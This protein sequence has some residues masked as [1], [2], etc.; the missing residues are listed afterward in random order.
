VYYKDELQGGSMKKNLD[1]RKKD[2][3]DFIL[4]ELFGHEITRPLTDEEYFHYVFHNAPKI[5]SVAFY[6]DFIM[7]VVFDNNDSLRVDVNRVKRDFLG[8]EDLTLE[9]FTHPLEV[10]YG[11]IVWSMMID[12]T[13]E[14]LFYYGIRITAN[15]TRSDK[16]P[17][18]FIF[19][20]TMKA[21]SFF[22]GGI[23]ITLHNTANL[24]KEPKGVCLA[25]GPY[26]SC[27]RA[28]AFY[29]H[30][31]WGRKAIQYETYMYQGKIKTLTMLIKIIRAILVYYQKP[32]LQNSESLLRKEQ[33]A[34]VNM[35]S[36]LQEICRNSTTTIIAMEKKSKCE[37]SKNDF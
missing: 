12:I 17:T 37:H 14:S 16:Y 3:F 32:L 23:N 28:I 13:V 26:N 2:G 24:D 4:R 29:G 19:I 18:H 1:Y 15:S 10:H 35:Y 30:D 31:N 27:A 34:I 6:D 33:N 21:P 22:G 5:R 7:D 8:F 36:L 25:I 9:L 11:S 20:H